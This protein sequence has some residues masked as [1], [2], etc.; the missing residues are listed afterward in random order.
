M[1]RKSTFPTETTPQELTPEAAE[2]ARLMVRQFCAYMEQEETLAPQENKLLLDAFE[3]VTGYK[4]DNLLA[5]M[6]LIFAG[7]IEAGMDIAAAIAGT[8]AEE[9]SR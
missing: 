3:E 5:Q 2:I 9:G 4:R 1:E 6:F 7:G 8:A